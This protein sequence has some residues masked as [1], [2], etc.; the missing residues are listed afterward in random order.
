MNVISKSEVSVHVVVKPRDAFVYCGVFLSNLDFNP[1]VQDIIIYGANPIFASNDTQTSLEINGLYASSDYDLY[2]ATKSL[3]DEYMGLASMLDTKQT[4]TTACCKTTMATLTT[5]ALYTA[6]SSLK[7]L[8]VSIDTLPS[9]TITVELYAYP[10]SDES[11]TKDSNLLFYPSIIQFTASDIATSSFIDVI[12]ADVPGVYGVAVSI[13]GSSADEYNVSFP[14]NNT[15]TV[16]DSGD[17]VPAP[18]PLSCDFSGNGDYITV[19]FDSVTNR[20][21]STGVIDCSHYLS[22]TDASEA[23]CYWSSD[24]LYL[25]VYQSVTDTM[26]EVGDIVTVNSNVIKASCVN[27][28]CHAS[29][30]YT[31]ATSLVVKTP[32]YLHLPTV[33]I[34]APK[35]KGL[36]ESYYLD[37]SSSSGNGGRTWSVVNISVISTANTT[38]LL[39]YITN[40][41]SYSYD[42]PSKISKDFFAAGSTYTF[43]VTLCNFLNSCSSGSLSMSVPLSSIP[44]P[45]VKIAGSS[46][47]YVYSYDEIVLRSSAYVTLCDGNV[48][49]SDISYSWKFFDSSYVAVAVTNKGH[50]ACRFELSSYTLTAGSYYYAKVTATY[51]G[52]STDAEVLIVVLTGSLIPV[53]D[54]GLSQTLR[55]NDVFYLNGTSSYDIDQQNVGVGLNYN[56]SCI[57]TSPT[58]SDSCS[59]IEYT[60][61][62]DSLLAL[63]VND[64][65]Y[66]GY[67]F[68]FTLRIDDGSDRFASTYSDINI[69]SES[70]PLVSI[71]T[72]SP[73]NSFDITA[74][75]TIEGSIDTATECHASWDVDD[76]SFDLSSVS[77]VPVEAVVT[78]HKLF[79]LKLSENV[80]TA[81]SSYVF[82]L[83][84]GSSN[85]SIQV[86]TNSPPI[87]GTFIVSPSDGVEFTTDYTLYASF[88]VDDDLPLTYEFLIDAGNVDDIIAPKGENKY[89][90]TQ[91]PMGE[92][93][94]DYH[95]ALIAKVYDYYGLGSSATASTVVNS[96]DLDTISH[97][98]VLLSVL[99]SV[100]NTNDDLALVTISLISNSLNK[101]NCTLAPNCSLL[102]RDN[103]SFIDHTCGSCFTDYLAVSS[104]SNAMCYSQ[105]SLETVLASG[106]FV[107][108]EC[109]LSCSNRGECEFY[110]VATEI[111][112]STCYDV[113]S[114][115]AAKCNCH[116]GYGG[117][118]C[119]YT[120][121]E[122]ASIIA[123]KRAVVEVLSD[124]V[125][126]TAGTKNEVTSWI[127][128]LT[129]IA[130]ESDTLDSTTA[131]SVLTLASSLFSDATEFDLEYTSST[132]TNV[133]C[134]VDTVSGI[135]SN[136]SS[137]LDIVSGFSNVVGDQ[138]VEGQDQVDIIYTSFRAGIL[139]ISGNGVDV[140][141]ISMALPIT[142]FEAYV[143]VDVPAVTY[144]VGASVDSFY[145]SA[146]S[147][148][149]QVY[150]SNNFTSNP[151]RIQVSDSSMLAS[152]LM[153]TVIN[154]FNQNYNVT[155]YDS[156]L[157]T[158][159]DPYEVSETNYTCPVSNVVLSHKCANFPYEFNRVTK[160]PATGYYPTCSF[161]D[162]SSS[163]AVI[164]SDASCNVLEYT[165]M[166]VTC[167][168]AIARRRILTP[169]RYLSSTASSID[170]AAIT[171]YSIDNFFDT[172]I[173]QGDVISTDNTGEVYIVL[174]LFGS[175]W[176]AGV[177]LLS[178]TLYQKASYKTEMKKVQPVVDEST[179]A[180]VP[181]SAGK[182]KLA[183]GNI[184]TKRDS[185]KEAIVELKEYLTHYIRELFPTVFIRD[186]SFKNFAS[187]IMN[188][189]LYLRPFNQGSDSLRQSVGIFRIVTT[190]S[191]L[192]FSLCLLYTL[193]SP[194]DDGDCTSQATSAECLSNK[195]LFDSTESSCQWRYSASTDSYHCYYRE[196]DVSY[197][198]LLY[199]AVMISAVNCSI[200]WLLD[201]IFVVICAPL[202]L[203]EGA[204]VQPDA[205]T[206][207][208]LLVSNLKDTI[209]QDS[210]QTVKQSMKTRKVVN[211][212]GNGN[213]N[214][215]VIAF[216]RKSMRR[217][218]G[219]SVFT[220]SDRGLDAYRR[221]MKR[222][223]V[224]KGISSSL[225][226]H[227]E[228]MKIGQLHRIIER[229]GG[230]RSNDADDELDIEATSDTSENFVTS[231]KENDVRAPTLLSLSLSGK[232]FRAIA[233]IQSAP[234]RSQKANRHTYE[235]LQ[236]NELRDNIIVQR[237]ML[238]DGD[239]DIFDEVWS[240][241]MD[242]LIS[243]TVEKQIKKVIKNVQSQSSR[244]LEDLRFM[245]EPSHVGLRL[246]HLFICDLLG[247]NTPA[248]YIFEQ[249]SLDY[250]THTRV[251]TM[252][253]K[254]SL[255]VLVICMNAFMFYY[256]IQ[257]SLVRGLRWQL[258]LLYGCMFQVI[259]EI[260]FNETM[261]CIWVHY[262][263]PSMAKPEIRDIYDVIT[264]SIEGFWSFNAGKSNKVY[265]DAT[266]YLFVSKKV[267]ASY[268]NLP[269]SIIIN[270]YQSYLPGYVGKI[271][272]K[273]SCEITSITKC[274]WKSLVALSQL[275][276]VIQRL[277]VRITQPIL[278]VIFFVLF[279]ALSDGPWIIAVALVAFVLLY[280][281]I[282][283]FTLKKYSEYDRADS[284]SRNYTR[285]RRNGVMDVEAQY[286]LRQSVLSSGESD[287]RDSNSSSSS[288]DENGN[289][290]ATPSRRSESPDLTKGPSVKQYTPQ[291]KQQL[292]EFFSENFEAK[293]DSSSD[294]DHDPYN[295]RRNEMDEYKNSQ[296]DIDSLSSTT[297]SNEIS[298][299][300]D[301]TSTVSSSSEEPETEESISDA[302]SS[303]SS[304][305]GSSDNAISSNVPL[306]V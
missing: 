249:K 21:G 241:G 17:S 9:E 29:Y 63:Y 173:N 124:I 181:D 127:T 86:L 136:V 50:S 69:V 232:S 267:A 255:V 33:S 291:E 85:S 268:G 122:I 295:T 112:L 8:L 98:S 281:S 66:I 182:R 45:V 238:S 279:S 250:F 269:E 42:P 137:M 157:N 81:R 188:N 19:T 236:F 46:V 143:G 211:R 204:K 87:S 32:A 7:S 57:T 40:D 62:S 117:K 233:P 304:S 248:C 244:Y 214:G 2:C 216:G 134:I 245:T 226:L 54:G 99:D 183:I 1:E 256:S 257:A 212:N 302:S 75:L 289:V 67:T 259:I 118:Y 88:W 189:H 140:S 23:K 52:I 198:M 190:Q 95:L 78:S 159:C 139:S 171:E 242:G 273:R 44:Y 174:V 215:T 38:D 271:W 274:L 209:K 162:V 76:S 68:R 156:Y 84:C 202:S 56:W 252:A 55:Y 168:C 71:S 283:F 18:I 247:K 125:S 166:Y 121:A 129:S 34:I 199:F 290:L 305:S 102:N 145:V 103:C 49:Y 200:G 22:F 105:S 64:A 270:H 97:T 172:A 108:K 113:D 170:T 298:E 231:G 147:F 195:S 287:G 70:G 5:K 28:D 213:F 79:V 116:D 53:I 227:K 4:F 60:Y 229:T 160:C 197:L 163:T 30:L 176:V 205:S 65:S 151:L 15:I 82:S 101:V 27:S 201:Q 150:G 243:D 104:D 254:V 235:D 286:K 169:Q 264:T 261:E 41:T 306:S 83:S 26:L 179:A 43:V 119:E 20:G 210:L 59:H 167:S 278:F 152:N 3:H 218:V 196:V 296:G 120:S 292:N 94:N 89:A 206:D 93:S 11:M 155:E 265:L 251:T 12:S 203:R 73:V 272:R 90:I 220:V 192:V 131:A 222:I 39:A 194:T 111:G 109:L 187:E 178:I 146:I 297:S 24:G 228:Q 126:G 135:V 77:L 303:T 48:T 208:D 177:L 301:S 91:L 61:I 284:L 240:L 51:S 25:Y 72:S 106:S 161:L 230:T 130:S 280:G 164:D 260:I 293:Y 14:L 58:Y 275:P 186:T 123:L 74:M 262:I 193:Q 224:L 266:T 110:N 219:E 37:I 114:T 13:S 300:S 221:I 128:S 239:L 299:K 96:L 217:N 141:N 36:C 207:S 92:V 288:D 234:L 115:C 149:A 80:L 223:E 107:S 263:I 35:V 258:T 246:M 225:E 158:T 180:V 277:F 10:L 100:A 144:P 132:Y 16:L 165:G 253:W 285:R 185:T 282:I 153:F 142:T 154:N 47:K 6:S 276:L 191:F 31:A 184:H 294:D 138:L 133:L 148:N 175:I 237:S